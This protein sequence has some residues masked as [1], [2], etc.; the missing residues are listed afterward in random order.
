[1]AKFISNFNAKSFMSELERDVKDAIL[2]EV[3]ERS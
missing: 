1:M 3:N 2:S